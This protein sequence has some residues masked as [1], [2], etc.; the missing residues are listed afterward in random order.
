MFW[1]KPD[2]TLKLNFTYS[3]HIYHKTELDKFKESLNLDGIDSSVASL[4]SG[5][6]SVDT[7]IKSIENLM[8]GMTT[9][10]GTKNMTFIL[11]WGIRTLMVFIHMYSFIYIFCYNFS[12]SFHYKLMVIG[13]PGNHGAAQVQM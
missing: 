8:K 10:Q 5:M 7:K 6:K 13:V 3:G 4:Q 11:R 12:K 9:K 1:I 2:E